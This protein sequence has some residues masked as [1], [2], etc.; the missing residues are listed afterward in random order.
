MSKELINK[1]KVV[2]ADTFV[3]YMKSHAAHWN[4][5]GPDFP[6]LHSFFGD[7][8][9]ELHDSVDVLAE[10]IR[11][12]DSFALC[13]L[14][15]IKQYATIEETESILKP[16]EMVNDLYDTNEKVIQTVTEAYNMAEELKMFGYSN[17]LQDRLTAHFKHRWMLKSIALRK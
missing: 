4:V 16:M 7:L 2:L 14:S 9:E 1:S 3:M 6:Q 11:Q 12:L 17:Y 8:Y 13:C 15:E 10:H 5:V